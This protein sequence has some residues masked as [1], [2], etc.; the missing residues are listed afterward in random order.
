METR[1]STNFGPLGA[2]KALKYAPQGP[3]FTYT[4]G[5]VNKYLSYACFPSFMVTQE[6]K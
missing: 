3:W 2:Q 6:N 5:G 4:W 1:I